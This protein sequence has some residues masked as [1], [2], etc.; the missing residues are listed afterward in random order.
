[1]LARD[2]PSLTSQAPEDEIK[3]QDPKEANHS[4]ATE[5]SSSSWSVNVPQHMQYHGTDQRQ[6]TAPAPGRGMIS[7]AASDDQH[8]ANEIDSPQLPG[9]TGHATTRGHGAATAGV[10]HP[11]TASSSSGPEHPALTSSS[12][13]PELPHPPTPELTQQIGFPA[14]GTDP[15]VTIQA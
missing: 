14:F 15:T 7:S 9:N 6:A 5:S 11:A 13:G 1:M 12:N 3:R 8:Y 4:A 10:P 2:F